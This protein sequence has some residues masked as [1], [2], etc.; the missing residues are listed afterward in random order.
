MITDMLPVL[1]MT[2]QSI[3]EPGFKLPNF[4]R[5]DIKTTGTNDT[6][7]DTHCQPADPN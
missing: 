1:V 3:F 2:L 4:G 5:V 7:T 6:Y